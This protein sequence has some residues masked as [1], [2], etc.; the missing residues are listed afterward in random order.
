L[1]TRNL[2]KP[3]ADAARANM[4]IRASLAELKG[5]DARRVEFMDSLA[6]GGEG[7]P[8]QKEPQRLYA[9]QQETVAA[10]CEIVVSQQERIELL[11]AAWKK[12]V[13]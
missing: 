13:K 5:V 11:E 12:S 8:S 7:G 10:L 2:N 4:T 6:R 1:D 9:W 3:H